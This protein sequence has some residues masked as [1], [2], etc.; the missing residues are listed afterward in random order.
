MNK[1]WILFLSF[2][3]GLFGKEKTDILFYLQDAGETYA[4]L[5]VIRKLEEKGI[6]T[7]VLIAGVAEDTAGQSGVPAARFRQ[8]SDFKVATPIDRSWGRSQKLP[9]SEIRVVVDEIETKEVVAGV[10]FELQGQILDLYSKKG[11]PTFAYWDNFNSDG[12]NPYFLT[13]HSVEKKAETLLLPS[14]ILEK[15]FENREGKAV[16]GQPTLQQWKTEIDAI[17]CGEL[18]R[19]LGIGADRKTA[20]FIGG[21]GTDFEEAL[22]L[23]L[24]GIAGIDDVQFLI[25]PHPKTK[26]AAFSSPNPN[27]RMLNGE[28]STIEAVALADLVL[29]HQS[30]VAFQ[31]LAIGKP[32]LHVIPP[33]QKFDS[34]PLQ[35]GL[36]KK[37]SRTEDFKDAV[38][39]A[40]QTPVSG[41]FDLMEIPENSVDL[42]VSALL[43]NLGV[44]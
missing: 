23:F 30:T 3:I 40:M 21:Y 29:C 13:A 24:K 15:A 9:D 11:I 44:E 19:K 12:E 35:Q 37:V 2:S 42:I 8:F 4:L 6:D 5:P 7:L 31:A 43:E 26:G 38:R 32:V 22:S 34:L 36:A 18:R 16:V 33:H 41:F 28:L 39:L 20:L 17:D 1:I 25:Q 10:A 14:Y 27:C